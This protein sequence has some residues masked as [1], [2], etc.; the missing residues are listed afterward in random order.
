MIP[1]DRRYSDNHQWAQ[2]GSDGVITVGITHHAQDLLGDL[3][4][5]EPPAL[6]RK[7]KMGEQCGVV[8]SVKSASD[9]YAPVSGEVTGVMLTSTPRLR[10]STRTL[11]ERGFSSSSPPTNPNGRRC[12]MPKPIK[13]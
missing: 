4:F 12:W 5:V 6:G 7:L 10:K 13:S 3:L 1:A 2:S 8:E 11:M 9:I